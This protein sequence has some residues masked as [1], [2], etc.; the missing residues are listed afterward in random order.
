MNQTTHLSLEDKINL[1]FNFIFN[2][3]SHIEE[4][5][6]WNSLSNKE[7]NELKKIKKE[8]TISLKELE[9]SLW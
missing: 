6:F 8:K 5:I 7:V 3:K 2:W 4:E 9:K 1:I